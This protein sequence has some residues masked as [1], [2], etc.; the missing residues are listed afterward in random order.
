MPWSLA[1]SLATFDTTQSHYTISGNR[2]VSRFPMFDKPCLLLIR[3]AQS[4]NNALDESQRV[5]D[6]PLT[7]LGEIQAVHLGKAVSRMVVNV[8]YSSPFLRALQTTRHIAQATGLKP[9]VRQDIFEQGGCY[10]G[11][12]AEDLDPEPGMT[13]QQIQQFA[14]EWTIDDRVTD[15]GWNDLQQY[16]SMQESR[17]RASKVVSWFDSVP[18]HRT[19]RVAMV[20]HADF[21]IR[22]IEAI[23]GRVDVEESF[24]AVI[25]T[26]ITC[27]SKS[28]GRWTLDFWNSYQHLD[29]ELVT[30]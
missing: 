24:G 30:C 13:F 1:Y 15:R 10:R 22:L 4:S 23:L 16:E 19:S 6:P 9:I 2:H 25:N 27:V 3:H 14:P 28:H 12:M 11:H 7:S 26:A 5:P 20:M 8:L 17:I 18:H 21:K 29:R